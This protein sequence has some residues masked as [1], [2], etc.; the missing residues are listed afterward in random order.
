MTRSCRR[1]PGEAGF[2][3]ITVMVAMAI[4]LTISSA[5][6]AGALSTGTGV[7]TDALS[8]RA[9]QAAEAGAQ[10]AIH[11]INLIQP[12]T[13]ACVTTMSSSPQAGSTWC[14][15]TAPESIGNGQSFKYQTS[16]EQ[17]GG[18]TGTTFGSSTS[19]RCLVSIGTAG[20]ISRRVV[21]RVVSSS[22]AT[23][24]PVAG[25]LGVNGV[26]IG[27]NATISGAVATNG[28]LKVNNNVTITGG[29]SLWANA[30]NPIGYSGPIIRVPTQYVLS[31]PN[32]IN[33]STTL[34]SKT[35]NDNGRLIAGANPSDP[36]S[37]GNGPSSACYYDTV[38]SPRTLSFSNNGSVTLGGAVYNFCSVEFHNNSQLNIAANARVVI[39]LDSPDRPG[40]GCKAGQ[41][42]FV[43]QNNATVSNPSGDPSAFQ[44]IVY[45]SNANPTIS[46]HN[47]LTFT[48][49]IYAPTT[50]IE[51]HNN[52]TLRGG[53]SAKSIKANN[54]ATW[55]SR[56][57]SL[58]FATTLVYF[59]GAWR[60]CPSTAAP[61][62]A[63]GTGCL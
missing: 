63:P 14:A 9:F 15:P 23:P 35:S 8:I 45:G 36:C 48:G 16:I 41:G 58:R 29:V 53:V 51:F 28:Q 44:L 56:V 2:A 18:C 62:T 32:M 24:F 31:P 5:M 12:A 13:N 25:L 17:A 57:G 39:F 38:D 7:N 33:P 50:A 46:F 54:N 21:E 40:S 43:A 37:H 52:A 61:V 27:N 22:G 47:N 59:R 19:E 20:G 42:R 4:V 10:T 3:M 1:P 34:D 30:P 55:D 6:A 26:E 60:Q 11:R 49:A